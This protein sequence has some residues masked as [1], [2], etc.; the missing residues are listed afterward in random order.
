MEVLGKDLTIRGYQLFEITQDPERLNRAKH[1]ITEG[2]ESG[3][4]QP[5]VSR[6]F[7]LSEMVEA[8]QYIESNAQIGKIVIEL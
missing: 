5:V 8:H 1:F 6:T 7:R 2:L 4:L 3:A